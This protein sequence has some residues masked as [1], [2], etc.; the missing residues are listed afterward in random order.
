MMMRVVQIKKDLR[1]YATKERKKTNERF[2][3]TA[4]GDYGEHDKFLGISNPDVRRVAKKYHDIDTEQ[5]QKLIT[6]QYNEERLFSLIVLVERFKCKKIGKRDEEKIYNFYVGNLKYVNNWNLVDL[7][8]SY[9][10][11]EYITNHQL[12]QK[13]LSTLVVSD[14]HWHRRVCILSTWAFSKRGNFTHTLIY[15]KQLLCDDDDL[16][17]RAVGWMLREVWKRD[18][19]ICE[20]FLQDN[21][22]QLSRTTLRCAIERMPEKRRKKFLKNTF[23]NF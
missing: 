16:M 5:L 17:H 9:I 6:S 18:K 19:N 20:K 23:D 22:H 12:Q 11:G 4:K 13:I 21:Y 3:K 15:A 2:F 1:Q 7:S 10:L 14:F 8:A